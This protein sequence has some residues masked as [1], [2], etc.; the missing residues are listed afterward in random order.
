V[1][2]DN[3]NFER[4]LDY[5]SSIQVQPGQGLLDF[6]AE[7]YEAAFDLFADLGPARSKLDI[8]LVIDTT[9]SM[10]DELNYLQT[11]FS[12]L[13]NAIEARFPNADQRWSLAVYR[14]VGDQYLVRSF[15]FSDDS[16]E[17]RTNLSAQRSDGGGD[18]PEGAAEALSEMNQL[19]WR[20]GTDV[21][22][23]AFWVAD[24]PHHAELATMAADAVRESQALGIHI[25]PVASS[26]I[27]ELTE[28][29]MRSAAQLTGGR[30]IFLTD[31]SG[32]GGEHKEPSIVCYFVTQLDQAI[33]RMVDIEM[34]GVYTEP[35]S[36]DIIRTGG[37][38]RDRACQLDSGV[39]QAF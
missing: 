10:S 22:R 18:F 33:L 19:D 15:D 9:G 31:D 6:S 11:E 38:P 16:A 30:Y 28:H 39:A 14:D 26:G 23:L 1:W 4:F 27:D 25:Y 12:A 13:S 32:V 17:F 2:D 5:R 36:V 21:A 7:E 20:T 29:T 3:R 35:S 34:S 24:A 37:N 8:A